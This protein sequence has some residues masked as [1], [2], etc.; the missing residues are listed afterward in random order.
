M[1]CRFCGQ[2]A[3]QQASRYSATT[4][5]CSGCVLALW[6]WLVEHGKGPPLEL[7]DEVQVNRHR[8]ALREGSGTFPAIV[9]P[10][11]SRLARYPRRSAARARRGKRGGGTLSR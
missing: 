1:K 8:R 7:V 5:A 3:D 4:V 11:S 10:L 2:Q 9:A 6:Q